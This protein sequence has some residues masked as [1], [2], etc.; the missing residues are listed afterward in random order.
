MDEP[1]ALGATNAGATYLL[2]GVAWGT[3]SRWE[4]LGIAV[5]AEVVDIL[6]LACRYKVEER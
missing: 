6:A 2:M 5:T 4:L 3:A 1:A